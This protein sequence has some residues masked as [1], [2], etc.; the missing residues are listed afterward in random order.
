[1]TGFLPRM[2]RY[3][4][5]LAITPSVFRAKGSDGAMHAAITFFSK[6]DLRTVHH[7]V[8]F[9]A[10]LE[11]QT[12][13]LRAAFPFADWRPWGPARKALN[14]F[15]RDAS[16]NAFLRAEYNLAAIDARLETPVDSQIAL[17]LHKEAPGR[18]PRWVS[19]VGLSSRD[20]RAYQ[21][22]AT[23]IAQKLGCH[24]GHL[25]FWFWRPTQP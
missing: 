24:R 23:E 20:H 15:L 10:F 17:A 1:M 11:E 6:L 8:S 14:V 25:D 12:A 2:Q 7:P 4:A 21:T 5:N 19:I 9:D 16:C 18:L 22:V 13:A 3:V